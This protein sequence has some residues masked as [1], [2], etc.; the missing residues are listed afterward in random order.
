MLNICYSQYIYTKTKIIL[1]FFVLQIYV[2]FFLFKYFTIFFS[3]RA[4]F[5]L[6]QDDCINECVSMAHFR[7]VACCKPMACIPL[8]LMLDQ[9]FNRNFCLI[10]FSYKKPLPFFCDIIYLRLYIIQHGMKISTF[11]LIKNATTNVI[12]YVIIQQRN[13][14]V[15]G[16][17]FYLFYFKS[18]YFDYSG[19]RWPGRPMTFPIGALQATPNS[20]PC[21]LGHSP[22]FNIY[23]Y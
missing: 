9:D 7:N 13:A 20:W 15:V 18:K 2:S 14:I 5:I 17:H 6:L 23:I 11:S 8:L 22:L 16:I 10:I 4:M 12:C 19:G 21:L 3:Y 1:F